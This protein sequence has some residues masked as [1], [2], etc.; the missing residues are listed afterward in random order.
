MARNK[1]LANTQLFQKLATRVTERA[2]P[3][4]P[5]YVSTVEGEEREWLADGVIA[6]EV[7]FDTSNRVLC[8]RKNDRACFVLVNFNA[9]TEL[10]DGLSLQPLNAGLFT[11][12]GAECDLVL[13]E[14]NELDL[15]ENVFIP[16]TSDYAG[17]SWEALAPFFQKLSVIAITPNGPFDNEGAIE[18]VA[19]LF[20]ACVPSIRT[21]SLDKAT[22][23]ACSELSLDIHSEVPALL[24]SH[25]LAAVRWEHCFLEV[26]RCIE[27]LLSLPSMIALKS[28]L[29]ISQT[30][31]ELSA[32]L[33]RVIGWRRTEEPGLIALFEGCE[34]A[35]KN[36][37]RQLIELVPALHRDYSTKTVAGYIYKLR[38]AIVHYRPATDLPNLPETAWRLLVNFLVEIV[39]I[40]YTKYR[41]ELARVD[42]HAPAAAIQDG[43]PSTLKAPV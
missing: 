16:N 1:I 22:L 38:N 27:R 8:V 24:L 32:S 20:G 9:P 34:T 31:I 29:G 19:L 3:D 14:I 17:H 5:R 26:Y 12:L 13:P 40:L 35:C 42:L 23:D 6:G 33:E 11:M 28:D 18:R 21:L 43:Q 37:H 4:T 2:I 10:P 25:A 15:H 39:V 36:F 41:L 30:A 7:R